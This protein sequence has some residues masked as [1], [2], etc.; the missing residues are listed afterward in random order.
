VASV[1]DDFSQSG[2]VL[3][4]GASMALSYRLAPDS[5]LSFTLSE[6]RSRGDIAS[7][8]TTFTSAQVNWSLALARRSSL[9]LGVRHSSSDS[10][11]R[12]YR[13]NAVLATYVHQF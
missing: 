10:L 7:Q 4:R 5:S 13:E 2:L 12:S 6:Q 3:Q 9:Q 8:K 1:V 11:A